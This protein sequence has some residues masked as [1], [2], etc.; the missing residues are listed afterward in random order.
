MT[1]EQAKRLAIR[2]AVENN[3][4]LLI[5][6]DHRSENAPGDNYGFCPAFG[7]HLLYP[8]STVL[9][10]VSADGTFIETRN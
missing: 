9:G 7:R 8:K 10:V 5:L 3:V 1:L 4:P 6:Q 2:D